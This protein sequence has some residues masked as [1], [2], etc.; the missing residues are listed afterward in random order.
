MRRPHR[1]FPALAFTVS[2]FLLLVEAPWAVEAV[3]TTGQKAA[4]PAARQAALARFPTLNGDRI[5]FVA[6][7]N[8]WSV[9]RAGGAATR[10]TADA[11]SDLM[12]RYS[13]DG[14]WIAFTG[15]YEQNRDVY[16]IP[17]AGGV[18]RRLT[19]ESD[20]VDDAPM[21]WGPNNLVLGW[22]PDSRSVLFLSRRESWNSW[23]GRIYSVPLEGGRPQALPLD[24]GGLLSWAPDGHRIAFN[25]IFR[26]F[27][28]W[29][30]YDG[31]LA[32]DI[33][34]YD[35]D[36]RE[37][38]HVTDWPGT[39][40]APMW[41]RQTI[42]FLADR[43]E[44]RRAN[45]WAYDT[46]TR[47]FRQVTHFTDF[48]IDFPS[49]GSRQGEAAGIVF[50]KGGKLFVL[51]LPDESLHEI[52]VQI[53]D[54]GTRTGASWVMAGNL[55]RAKDMAGGD[56][57]DLAPNGKRAVFSA[58]GDLFTVPAEFGNTRNLTATPGADED[59]PAWSHDG[60][61]IAYTTDAGGEQQIAVRPAEGGAERVL[62]SFPAGYRFAPVWSPADDRIAFSDSDHR[63]WIV[64]VAGG[65]P[66]EVAQSDWAEIHD[67]AWAPDGR[68]LAYS[69][70]ESNRRSGIW[71]YSLERARS[72]RVSDA[73]A[74]DFSP[75]FDPRGRYLYFLSQRREIAQ[76]HEQELDVAAVKSTGV[77]V[78]TLTASVAPPF[79]PRSDEGS[80]DAA[81]AADAKD[82]P[83]KPGAIKPIEIDPAGL[84]RRAEP[85]PVPP[86]GVTGLDVRGDQVFYY[87]SPPQGTEGPVPGERSSL[88]VFDMKKRKDALVLEG[89][90][91]WVLSADGTHLLYRSEGAYKVAAARADA[92]KAG[93]DGPRALDFSHMRMRTDL[94]REWAEMF[95]NAWRL[96][97]DFFYSP[98]MN[99]VDWR[100][101]H[102]RYGS[103]LPLAGSREDLNY[104]IGEMLGELG[105]SHTYVGGGDRPAAQ[106]PVTTA[107]LGVDLR[108]DAKAQRYVIGRILSGDN[109]RPQYRSPLATAGVDAR[110]GDYLLA[111]DDT[112]L[113]APADPAALLVGKADQTVR[114]TLSDAPTGRRRTV[115]IQPVHNELS[116]REQAWIDDKLARV[117]EASKGRVGYLY[118][119]NMSGL[120]MEQFLR[121]FYGQ[122]DREALI[123]DDRWNG[124]GFIDQ[125]LLERLRRVVVGMNTNRNGVASTAP[126]TLLAGP[127][128][129]LINHYSASD[130]DIFP[131]YFRKY[132][133]GPLL[134]TRTW[135]GVRGIR[136]E[137]FLLD[138]GYITVPEDSLYGLDSKWNIE[139]HGVDPDVLV[140][141][142]PADWMAGR[143][144]Q[145]EAAITLLMS[146]LPA[147]PARPP[148][149]PALLPAY[150]VPG[151]E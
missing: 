29:K 132:G 116:L 103:L 126:E 56:D 83:W 108:L 33:D 91:G 121:Q 117:T 85:L 120:G 65:A 102:E 84:M 144:P 110:E 71:L 89:V 114:L 70:N 118:L 139:N 145:L 69:R 106:R 124:G 51:D 8:L 42:Y 113:H 146:K 76:L 47:A 131:F 143:D 136:G 39:E 149:R 135:G 9:A 109:T 48:D 10:L 24:R 137:L 82:E 112:E 46:G 64:D 49:L 5:V 52:P 150:P 63:L 99:G 34:I 4:E 87:V 20:V 32:Q 78:A 60:R 90:D 1:M 122:L 105:N 96:E 36:T 81:A 61:W 142:S 134:G 45:I 54:D 93:D 37:L 94:R 43:G 97:R 92:A 95:D 35:F 44:S 115:V 111:I 72:V 6:H 25:R 31:G 140:D 13:P 67:Y 50:Q 151:S 100:Q 127:K 3:T 40:T 22:T 41:Y 101:V 129:C 16:V 148:Q 23:F 68:W 119:S 11:G 19:F 98:V 86:A 14:K 74:N 88:R 59:H 66:R 73:R 27:R 141:D 28:T 62:T 38:T 147:E 125:I 30:R 12:P 2:L 123:V 75:V 104:L 55:V 18:A 133:L 7:D 130:G 15:E 26:N 21:R 80:F 138:G 58:R 79:G 53:P 77:F 17:A 128:V 107:W 57:F